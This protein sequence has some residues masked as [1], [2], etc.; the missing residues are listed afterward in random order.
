MK[1]IKKWKI[2]NEGRKAK[3][4]V[5]PIAQ[6]RK[7]QNKKT[8]EFLNTW[9]DK[10][11]EDDKDIPFETGYVIFKVDYEPW[12]AAVKA[13]PEE[14]VEEDGVFAGNAFDTL[15]QFEKYMEKLKKLGATD[16]RVGGFHNDTLYCDTLYFKMDKE[17][18]KL[19]YKIKPKPDEHWIEKQSGD[20]RFWWD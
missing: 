13:L 17:N 6:M 7:E 15:K 16:I 1:T 19:A 5:D 8:S 10:V 3:L 20:V 2:F 12:M 4:Y 9:F 11:Y 18:Y 14:I